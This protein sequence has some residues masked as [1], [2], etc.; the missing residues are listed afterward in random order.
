M[1]QSIQ[2][3]F[4]GVFPPPVTVVTYQG[5]TS[6]PEN[7]S[8]FPI[9]L[10]WPEIGHVSTFN[11]SL[12]KRNGIPRGGRSPPPRKRGMVSACATDSNCPTPTLRTP[13]P[14]LYHVGVPPTLSPAS[15]YTC[16][17]SPLPFPSRLISGAEQLRCLCPLRLMSP[18][19]Y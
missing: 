9:I 16:P 1:K 7:L 6:L 19:A 14:I 18:Q 12:D 17:I 15:A 2:I 10:Y 11:Q 5:K 4:K 3:N 8:R 13:P